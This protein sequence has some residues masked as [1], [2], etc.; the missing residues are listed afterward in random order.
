[1]LRVN[2]PEQHRFAG[3]NDLPRSP[4]KQ[5][6]DLQEPGLA[7]SLFW[8]RYEQVRRPERRLKR[9]RVKDSQHDGVSRARAEVD[10]TVDERRERVGETLFVRGH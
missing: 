10:V 9:P 4:Y 6:E 7:T 1:M 5:L 3:L 2:L 8:R